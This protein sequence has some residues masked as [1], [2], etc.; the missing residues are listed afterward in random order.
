MEDLY[1]ETIVNDNADEEGQSRARRFLN[2]QMRFIST[3]RYEL[4]MNIITILNA[5]TV[6]FRTL[7]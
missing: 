5:F 3:P 2:N 7:Q 6:F 1:S 4:A